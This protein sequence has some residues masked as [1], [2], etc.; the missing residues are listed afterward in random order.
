MGVFSAEGS[1]I[2]LMYKK[3]GLKNLPFFIYL[4]E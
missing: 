4:I 3:A 2:C 1:L